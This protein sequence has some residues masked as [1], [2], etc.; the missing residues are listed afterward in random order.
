MFDIG[1]QELF[2]VAVLAIIVVGPKDLPRAIRAVTAALRKARGMARE[3]QNGLDDIVRE[4]DLDDIKKEAQ[5]AAG[6]NLADEIENQIDPTGEV[7]KE[8]EDMTN[9]EDET[10][11][12]SDVSPK[13]PDESDV[14]PKVTDKA[15]G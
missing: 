14:E 1:W 3:F 11:V 13:E 5:A 15:E 6:F 9:L 2:I 10:D 12:S 4:A 7:T 8:L